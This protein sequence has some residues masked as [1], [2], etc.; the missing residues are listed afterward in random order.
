M[1]CN[2]PP[3]NWY[4]TRDKDHEGPC[5]ARST[6]INY[7][8]P[9]ILYRDFDIQ[10]NE[11]I[12]MDQNFN[13]S[14]SRSLIQS[15]QLVIGRFSVLPFYKE[16]VKD[17]GTNNSKLINSWEQ[18]SFVADIGQWYPVIKDYTPE[19]WSMRVGTNNLPTDCSFVLKGA[20]N[21]IKR[22][23][24]TH[25]FA[26]TRADVSDVYERLLDDTMV[27]QQEIFARRYVPLRKL[28]ESVNGMPI[29]QEYR[30]FICYGKIVSSGFYWSSHADEVIHY[31]FDQAAHVNNFVIKV[32]NL[33]GDKCNFYTIDIGITEEGNPIVIE[34]N[35][36][37]MAGLSENDPF[38]MYKN[39]KN[40]INA[41]NNS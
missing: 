6:L 35:D 34:L 2:R 30:F 24:T 27:G 14:S 21:S 26:R 32:A 23:W 17:L 1:I 8:Q 11:R 3:K 33:I 29:T 20:T 40:I 5:A 4:C 19:T 31:N 41:K 37:Q 39:L 7:I 16:L 15:D 9:I 13:I 12:A 25:M 28:G 10:D 22:L 36:G 38:I 18:H